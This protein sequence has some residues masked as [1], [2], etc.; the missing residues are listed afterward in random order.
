MAN[1]DNPV[2]VNLLADSAGD[3]LEI[4]KDA[5]P[6][7]YSTT[8]AA[9]VV[10]MKDTTAAA[11][12]VLPPAI[13]FDMES[14]GDGDVD[15]GAE[16][17][18]SIWTGV[19]GTMTKSG[20]GSGHSFTATGELRAFGAG[21]YNELGGFV[22][23]LTNL[24][25]N[26]GVTV[27]VEVLVRDSGDGGATKFNTLLQGVNAR[28][29]KWHTTTRRS[30]AFLASSEG[31]QAIDAILMT[32]PSES[33]SWKLGI[34]FSRATF[35]TGLAAVFPNNTNLSWINAAGVSK[36]GM[37]LSG[38]DELTLRMAGTG[39]NTVRIDKSDGSN[40]FLVDTNANDAVSIFVGGAVKRIGVGSADSAGA[41]FRQLIVP[42]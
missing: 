5:A 3:R 37:F 22:G 29:A 24:G 11:A 20:D 6:L 10:Q 31:D 17:S 9:F 38:A 15:S 14:T 4:E 36:V 30:S 25:S 41:G 16:I 8:R 2:I 21:G 39:T 40:R 27:G 13:V 12:Q 7:N 23:T 42:N 26:L 19:T 18:N 32:N 33:G 35:S 28:V 1:W 34:D